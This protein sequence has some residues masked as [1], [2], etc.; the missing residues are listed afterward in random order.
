MSAEHPTLAPPTTLARTSP[1]ARE[2]GRLRQHALEALLLAGTMF[3]IVAS[4]G[5]TA[6]VALRGDAQTEDLTFAGT[7]RELSLVLESRGADRIAQLE[8]A[9]LRVGDAIVI[10]DT[11]ALLA[12][13]ADE[14][15]VAKGGFI[16]D[17][18]AL[19]NDHAIRRAL[20]EAE[21]GDVA[22][23]ASP[24]DG[25]SLL[26]AVWGDDGRR[27][28]A[29]RPSPWA[30][31]VRS[32][33]AE[34]NW[35]EVRTSDW[36]RSGGLLGLEGDVALAANVA[37][38]SRARLNGRDCTI[39]ADAPRLLLYCRSALAS[40]IGRFY[41]IGFELHPSD[42]TLGA[43]SAFSYRPRAVWRNG[44]SH[45]F[46]RE[47]VRPGDVFDVPWV[48]PFMLS[49]SERGT[50][51]AGQWINGRQSFTNQRLGT[52]SFFAA[53]GRSAASAQAAPL[54]LGL[55]AALSTE[56]ETEARRFMADAGPLLR[57]MSVVIIDARTG[58]LKAIAEPARRSDADPLLAFEPLLVGSVV[59][60][61]VAA[62]I[63][64]RR[65]ALGTMALHW[66]GDSVRIVAN[67]PLQRGFA[68][69]ANGCAGSIAFDAFL[70][71][72]S[73][74]YAAELLVR[75]LRADGFRPDGDGEQ[76]VPRAVLERSSLGTGLAEAF[77]VDAFGYRT[78]GRNPALWSDVGADGTQGAP[79]TANR[80]LLP[81]E[82]RPWILFPESDGTRLDLLAR[83]AFGGW[84]NRWT[85]IGVAEAYARIATGREVRTTI[86]RRGPSDASAEP[87]PP[88]VAT[89]FGRVRAALRGVGVDGT[90]SGLNARMGA[91]LPDGLTL[92]SK[93]GTLNEDTDRFKSLALAIG[94]PTGSQPAAP[95][96]CG[97][98]AV[99]YFEF[100]SDARP[101]RQRA[102]LPAVH[103]AFAQEALATVLARHWER[104]S[105]CSPQAGGTE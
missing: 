31:T 13:P 1:P 22:A 19:F 59:K 95:L 70:R 24:G 25:P 7:L 68:N 33:Y 85:L 28:L 40:D 50:L 5:V 34:R 32:P 23:A 75:S 56:L 83:Y 73:N 16:A 53:A 8:R 42:A 30:L 67:V 71:C 9:E 92:L 47:D 46:G 88:H 77:D 4:M 6:L 2:P 15:A 62:A 37:D 96:G 76:I 26:R 101:R 14:P 20:I 63:L 45:T 91:A 51:A 54:V 102:T 27:R 3:A 29:D 43:A 89:A 79:K 10:V 94:V 81:W 52:I 99:S 104:I 103:I 55:D 12:R 80:A 66:A 21:L 105:G 93:T 60:P 86:F 36:R 90:A 100:G 82:S 58:E 38:G 65:P 39:R 57:R 35:R 87:V 48:G 49:A 61:M 18:A 78:A 97:L 69:A 44:A 17:H 84:E 11:V 72:S 74:Q 98:V 41:D 64:A